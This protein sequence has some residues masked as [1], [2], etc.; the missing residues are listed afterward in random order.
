MDTRG[1]HVLLGSLALAVCAFAAGAGA[2]AVYSDKAAFVAATAPDR[3][4]T[5]ED[6]PTGSGAVRVG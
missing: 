6:V 5:F 1:I 2:A 3:T 4:A